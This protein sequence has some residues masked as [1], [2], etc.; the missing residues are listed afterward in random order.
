MRIVKCSALLLLLVI[1]GVAS[2]FGYADANGNGTSIP[3]Y[4]AVTMGLGGARAIGFGDALSVLTNP[5]DIYRIPG[6]S[7]TMSI[8]PAVLIESFEDTTGYHDFNWIALSN[9]SAAMKFQASS[10]L[11]MGAGIARISDFSFE[12]RYYDRDLV[13]G[14][15]IEAVELVS[16]G[17][18][19]E[20]AAGFSWHPESWINVG[21]SGGL[22]F[23]E[24]SYDS[25][26]EDRVHPENDTTVSIG[27]NESEFCWHAG[28]MIP[29]RM[30]SIGVSWASATDHYD[31]RIAAGA[32]L[33]TG[34]L[35]QGALGIE[36]EIVDPGDANNLEG[37]FIGQLSPSNS[38]TFRGALSFIDRN[39]EVE[40]QGVGLSFG[41]A[42]GLGR[43]TLNGAFS[44]SSITRES[45]A[46]SV[47]D[48]I[49]IK[50][51]QSLLSF[52]LNWNL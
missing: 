5:A 23:G 31:A 52:G 40:S 17:G 32:L 28:I 11:A 37:R 18:L 51:S 24:A 30:A 34:E 47:W 19:Y 16:R 9:L 15:I 14:D 1:S 8:G 33:Y 20:S 3:G 41:A 10:K 12:G 21:F 38:L 42:I 43:I 48:P 7:F 4:N 49:D 50:L 13:S 36:A 6:T 2:A 45:Y 35:K 46:F 29:L 26:F 27:W 25:T 22:R 44:W 39:E